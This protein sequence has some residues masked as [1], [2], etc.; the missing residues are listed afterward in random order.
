MTMPRHSLLS[1]KRNAVPLGGLITLV[2]LYWYPVLSL[3]DRLIAA[4]GQS[5]NS[6]SIL[7]ILG[8]SLAFYSSYVYSSPSFPERTKLH[9]FNVFLALV[10]SFFFRWWFLFITVSSACLKHNDWHHWIPLM[11][12]GGVPLA[13]AMATG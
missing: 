2:Y 10:S 8:P 11:V 13:L 3:R 6:V 5:L 12:L 7:V 4:C 1:I 9:G